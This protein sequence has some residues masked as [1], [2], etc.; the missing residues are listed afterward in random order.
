MSGIRFQSQEKPGRA[1]GGL[2]ERAVTFPDG[3]CSAWRQPLES[4]G[5]GNQP[6]FGRMNLQGREK[7]RGGREQALKEQKENP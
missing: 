2:P 5:Q 3:C 7:E 4:E 1:A 6:R